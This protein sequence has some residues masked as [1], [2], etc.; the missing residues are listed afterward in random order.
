MIALAFYLLWMFAN[1]ALINIA[2]KTGWNHDPGFVGPF[3][4]VLVA[5]LTLI[6]L[7]A[8]KKAQ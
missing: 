1:A 4:I 8:T 2:V 7:N 5:N 6:L 3:L